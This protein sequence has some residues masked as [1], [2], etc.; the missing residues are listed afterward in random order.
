MKILKVTQFNNGY[1]CQCCRQDW[2]ETEWIDESELPNIEK[3]FEE[4]LPKFYKNGNEGG[5]VGTLFE[6]DGE[7][8]FGIYADIYRAG[9]TFYAYKG[10]VDNEEEMEIPCDYNVFAPKF[11]LSGL[12]SFYNIKE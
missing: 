4:N 1:G 7:V 2:T 8:L 10:T 12:K 11:D 6:K 5:M 3:F 9:F